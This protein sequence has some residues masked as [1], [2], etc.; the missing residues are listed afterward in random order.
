LL[1]QLRT[2]SAT[3]LLSALLAV[4]ASLFT[5]AA[6]AQGCSPSVSPSPLRKGATATL[7]ANC[8]GVAGGN[9][10]YTYNAPGFGLTQANQGATLVVPNWSGTQVR[11][12]GS[13]VLSVSN[14][15]NASS[16][17]LT[18]T[19][20]SAGVL[21]IDAGNNQTGPASQPLPVALR[22]RVLEGG[23]PVAGEPVYW[24]TFDGVTG[25]GSLQ[26]VALTQTDAN[27]FASI[28]FTPPNANAGRRVSAVIGTNGSFIGGTS[29]ALFTINVTPAP[30]GGP[31]PATP[32]QG[33]ASAQ[34]VALAQVTVN[35]V[36]VQINAV[37]NRLRYL[38]LGG[39]G[40]FRQDLRVAVDGQGVPVPSGG[41]SDSGSKKDDN[42]DSGGTQGRGEEGQ[43]T[44]TSRWGAYISGGV[45]VTQLKAVGDQPG[46]DL[47]TNGLTFGVD[48]RLS[49]S[50]VLGAA[51]GGMRANT[52]LSGA[53]GSQDARATSLTTYVSFAPSAATYIDVAASF[54]RNR[55]E[56]SR[57]Q[58]SGGY[59]AATTNGDGL[60][61]SV[62]TGYEWRSGRYALQPYLRA[63]TLRAT[64]DA[65]T[66]IGQA[67]LELSEQRLTSTVLTLGAQAQASYS[68]GGAVLLPHVRFE[69][70]QQTQ[71]IARA[72][73][74]RLLGSS[75]QVLVDQAVLIDRRFGQ[76]GLGLSAQFARGLTGFADY[77]QLFAKQNFK[78]RR[79][80][81]G[82]K[83]EF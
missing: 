29:E 44:T 6:Q 49:K 24:T 7:T 20:I 4:A 1:D 67:P 3:A 26:N 9:T 66:E 28:N 34:S 13:Y 2:T 38:R 59:A 50:W 80:S 18:F 51:V 14:A 16:G 70:Q 45:D 5:P 71:N 15:S 57:L 82:L 60:G 33:R 53:A 62:S 36:Q 40:G 23:T 69:V 52:D 47:D 21:G 76:F 48:Y 56:L 25:T 19:Y 32:D 10:Q 37:Q 31:A 42:A 81:V 39:G 78:S 54:S 11:P 75:T 46:F 68:I 35:T 8:N 17:V 64:V 43:G 12:S 55:Y 73:S 72:V 77:E 63:D 61:L 83:V 41:Q 27:G 79:G 30:G 74:A 22:V 65:F 58:T